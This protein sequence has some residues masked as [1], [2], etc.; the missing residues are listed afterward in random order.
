MESDA[1][2]QEE[3]QHTK[4]AW[5][6]SDHPLLVEDN[7]SRTVS[8]FAEWGEAGSHEISSTVEPEKDEL[9]QSRVD[10]TEITKEIAGYRRT[11]HQK[12]PQLKANRVDDLRHKRAKEL[13]NQ[14]SRVGKKEEAIS[15]N[16]SS[17]WVSFGSEGENKSWVANAFDNMTEELDGLHLVPAVS[18]EGSDSGVGHDETT[19]LRED[20]SIQ[21]EFGDTHIREPANDLVSMVSDEGDNDSIFLK[22]KPSGDLRSQ[23]QMLHE[24]ESIGHDKEDLHRS[25][26]EELL[27]LASF[28]KTPVNQ[29]SRERKKLTK[30]MF[31]GK[32]PQ[33]EIIEEDKR[34]DPS[35]Q[36][37]FMKASMQIKRCQSIHFKRGPLSTNNS[38]LDTASEVGTD[39]LSHIEGPTGPHVFVKAESFSSGTIS[40]LT[41]QRSLPHSDNFGKGMDVFGASSR[42]GSDSQSSEDRSSKNLNQ[43][44]AK[45]KYTKSKPLGASNEE[46]KMLNLFMSI[47]GPKL[48]VSRLSIEDR[49]EIHNKALRVGLPE[50]FIHRALDQTVGIL[51][52]EEA[53]SVASCDS[54]S[55]S[56]AMTKQS[57]DTE[58]SYSIAYTRDDETVSYH[59]YRMSKTAQKTE[60]G[61]TYGC[62]G[63]FKSSLWVDSGLVADE[64]RES[65]AAVISRDSESFDDTT[66]VSNN[67]QAT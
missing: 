49:E 42:I 16:T 32:G 10:R 17:E 31:L 58:G 21:S 26:Q 2:A 6:A 59:T 34:V 64:I 25:E 23:V 65:V 47:A 33:M 54:D 53:E 55:A 9:V 11:R 8:T 29:Q 56:A 35:N 60:V 46:L 36:S 38:L 37:S 13:L 50:G 27:S 48:K 51:R 1:L 28:S 61:E 18:L 39:V 52:W 3:S 43:S 44:S 24:T 41:H 4:D 67:N 40:V 7:S 15:W 45:R 57:A 14:V 62:F 12:I 19:S 5:G 22:M 30:N 66:Q 63:N 20:E